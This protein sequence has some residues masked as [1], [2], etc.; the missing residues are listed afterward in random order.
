MLTELKIAEDLQ[1]DASFLQDWQQ[2]NFVNL[3]S[4]GVLTGYINAKDLACPMPLL[5]LKMAL[6]QTSVGNH[7]YLT[8]TDANSE[9]DIGSFCNHL[10]YFFTF[11][12]SLDSQNDTIFHLFI[13]KNC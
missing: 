12:K 7:V 4:T 11:E 1:Q 8:A 5:K 3:P 6:K 13:T 2:A 10:G 9:R